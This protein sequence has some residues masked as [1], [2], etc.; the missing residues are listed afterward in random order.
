MTANL[1]VALPAADYRAS[2]PDTRGWLYNPTGGAGGPF[3]DYDYPAAL[4]KAFEA[5]RNSA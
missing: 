5:N 1:K 4:G 2:A 3:N